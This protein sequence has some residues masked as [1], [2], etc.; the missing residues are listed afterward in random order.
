MNK[1]SSPLFSREQFPAFFTDEEIHEK[2][3]GS[4]ESEVGVGG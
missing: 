4:T 1:S 3:Q 2:S